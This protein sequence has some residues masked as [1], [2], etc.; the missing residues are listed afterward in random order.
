MEYFNSAIP[1]ILVIG[2]G[3]ITSLNKKLEQSKTNERELY[4]INGDL[5]V[6]NAEIKGEYREAVARLDERSKFAVYKDK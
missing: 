5:R 6:E 4:K 3:L 2:G 1:I